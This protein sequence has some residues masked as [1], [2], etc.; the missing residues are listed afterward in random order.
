MGGRELRRRL[1]SPAVPGGGAAARTV[2]VLSG[3]AKT[4]WFAVDDMGPFVRMCSRSAREAGAV[5]E[6]AGVGLLRAPPG[7]RREWTATSATE[8]NTGAA[9]VYDTP[10]LDGLI[11]RE[12]EARV[13]SW[14][15]SA[16]LPPGRVCWRLGSGAGRLGI[17]L[18]C[19]GHRV[20]CL[21][22]SEGMAGPVPVSGCETRAFPRIPSPC[23]PETCTH[24]PFPA[25]TSMRWSPSA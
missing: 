6:T 12:R 24:S 2:E 15:E 16:G 3:A 23:L 18:A 14:L 11:Y 21:D 8:R 7:P 17:Q 19:R 4:A 13:A 1:K 22:S 9:D 25:I 20:L 5:S 10:T